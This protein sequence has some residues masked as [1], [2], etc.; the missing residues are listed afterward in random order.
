MP[1]L[2]DGESRGGQF[3]RQD[4]SV[5]RRWLEEID[6]LFA[7]PG[8]VIIFG[9]AIGEA[10]ALVQRSLG[11]DTVDPRQ[12]G[13][14]VPVNTREAQATV[15]KHGYYLSGGGEGVVIVHAAERFQYPTI[16]DSYAAGETRR[17]GALHDDDTVGTQELRSFFDYGFRRFHVS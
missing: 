14:R 10:H 11:E 15:G 13:K 16:K 7:G 5:T 2:Q 9:G 8:V 1:A 3:C 6:T 12:T 4:A 17:I